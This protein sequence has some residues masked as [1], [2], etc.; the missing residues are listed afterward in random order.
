M[1]NK[2]NSI[3]CKVCRDSGKSE[4]VYTSHR[5]KDKMGKVCCPTLLSQECRYC[6]ELGHTVK[7]CQRLAD[8]KKRE[9]RFQRARQE[10]EMREIRNMEEA[11]KL[12]ETS[13]TVKPKP[14]LAGSRFGALCSDSDSDSEQ[15]KKP[16]KR[17]VVQKK[18]TPETVQEE[19]PALSSPNITVRPHQA[20]WAKVVSNPVP[21]P[22]Q[23]KKLTVSLPVP[24]KDAWSDD[25]EEKPVQVAEAYPFP[26][27][28][29]KDRLLFAGLRKGTLSWADMDS[30]SDD[31]E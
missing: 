4:D 26:A 16:V 28:S 19:F 22:T 5:V 6:C 17:I 11:Q 30:S 21:A 3:V 24:Q 1:A 20:N 15:E 8:F 25:E 23:L 29:E 13:A 14:L 2:V 10:E 31:E 7:F 12:R 9:V 27:R 18:K